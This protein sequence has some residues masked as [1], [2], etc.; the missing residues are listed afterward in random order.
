M[1]DTRFKNVLIIAYEFPPSAGGGVQRVTKLA[2]Y[3]PESGWRPY[4]LTG[5]PVPGRPVDETLLEQVADVRITRVPSTDPSSAIARVLAPIKR[6]RRRPADTSPGI[7]GGATSGAAGTPFSTRAVRAVW[8]DPAALWAR[9]VPSA[10]K[11]LHQE[12]GFDAVLA[13][14]PP[15]SALVAGARAATALGVPFVADVRDPW[16]GNPGYRWPDSAR[17]DAR[18]LALEREVMTSAAAAVTVSD[19]ITAEA[20]EMGARHA[21]TVP[22]GFDPA[23]LPHWEPQGGPLRI[24]FMGRFYGSTDPTPFFDGVALAVRRG[25]PASDLVI[26]VLGQMS[27]FVKGAVS[28]RGLEEHIVYHGFRPHAEALRIVSAADAG[29]VALTD[30]PGAEANYTGKLFEYLGMGLPVL[31]VAPSRGVAAALVRDAHAGYAIPYGDTEAVADAL[32]EMAAAKAAGT[33][34]HRPVDS[35]VAAF[36]RRRQAARIA[37]LLDSVVEPHHG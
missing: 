20:L 26:D 8:L 30:H 15:H 33:G 28:S 11:R 17:K 1:N 13:S 12:I 6:L 36:D 18:S 34:H 31:L 23:D 27:A 32:D 25:G 16:R 37:A 29:L 9:R 2:R 14:G 24:A 7:S 10:A 22:N 3:L 35:V 19:P 4:V 5:T 21:I